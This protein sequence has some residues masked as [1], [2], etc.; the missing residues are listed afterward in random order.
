[1]IAAQLETAADGLAPKIRRGRLGRLPYTVVVGERGMVA[2]VVSA[3]T[4][5]RKQLAERGRSLRNGPQ[6]SWS[7]ARKFR[8]SVGIPMRPPA[9][10]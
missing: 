3:R 8:L 6:R 9:L 4:R 7:G 5:Q 2:R 10:Q 1:V